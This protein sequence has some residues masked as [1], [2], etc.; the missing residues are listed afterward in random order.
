MIDAGN[1]DDVIDVIGQLRDRQRRQKLRFQLVASASRSDRL[2]THAQSFLL[3]HQALAALV[4]LR[5]QFPDRR[6]GCRNTP[7]RHFSRSSLAVRPE[8][9]LPRLLKRAP[10]CDAMMGALESSASLIVLSETFETSSSIPQRFITNKSKPVVLF[11]TA[12]TRQL[13][14]LLLA[15]PLARPAGKILCGGQQ[16]SIAWPPNPSNNRSCPRFRFAIAQG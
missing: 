9:S 15:S 5:R 11:L 3:C 8:L 4:R 12:P 13:F 6:T 10:W 2:H 7:R 14:V 1:L 16:S